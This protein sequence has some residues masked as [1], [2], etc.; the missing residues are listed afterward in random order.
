MME[1]LKEKDKHAPA[2]VSVHKTATMMADSYNVTQI[3]SETILA[4]YFPEGTNGPL[5]KFPLKK[6]GAG[7]PPGIDQTL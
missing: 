7:D 4:K 5:T 3:E 2:F 6:K 1:L